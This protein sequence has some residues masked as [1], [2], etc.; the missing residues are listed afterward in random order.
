MVHGHRRP[1]QRQ[2]QGGGETRT[3]QQGTGQPR[4]LRVG[5]QVDVATAQ[6]G[7]GE[8]LAREGNDSSD[9]IA[10]GQFGHHAPVGLVH[11][12]LA[13]QDVRQ[14]PGHALS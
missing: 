11:V 7:L 8:H 5:H 9:V 4:T 12:G 1:P 14:E 6:P 3:H 2:A 10:R 13:V